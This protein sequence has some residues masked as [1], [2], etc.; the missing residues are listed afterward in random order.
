MAALTLTTLLPT[1]TRFLGLLTRFVLLAV[2]A[3]VT[4]P[5]PHPCLQPGEA[6]VLA[7]VFVGRSLLPPISVSHSPRPNCA[8]GLVLIVWICLAPACRTRRERP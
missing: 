3:A 5:R 6:I 8:P 7:R 4:T 2:L 1:L